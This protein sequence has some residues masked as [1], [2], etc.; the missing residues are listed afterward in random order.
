M[1]VGNRVEVLENGQDEI[2]QAVGEV[3]DIIKQ[4]EDLMNTYRDQLDDFE[5]RDCRQ[6]IQI[7]DLPEKYNSN[8]LLV[9][10]QKLFSQIMG[11]AASEHVEIDRVHRTTPFVSQNKDRPRDVICKIHKYSVKETI[12]RIVQ[13]TPLIE[14]E[15]TQ[16]SLFPDISRRTL[17][18]RRM[19]RP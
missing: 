6:N 5:N 12:M 17:M 7:R 16:I 15:G 10:I 13:Y 11:S 4:Q 14:Y 18:Q 8:D 1:A 19:V 2:T 3:H 9:T